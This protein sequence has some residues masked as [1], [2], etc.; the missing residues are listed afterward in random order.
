VEPE[1]EGLA[2]R[3][4]DPRPRS[5]RRAPPALTFAGAGL[6]ACAAAASCSHHKGAAGAA[7]A[8]D[9]IVAPA[10]MQRLT[11]AQYDNTV[12]DLLGAGGDP[13]AA[14]AEDEEQAGYAAN[15]QLPVQ[16]LQL[17][18]YQQAAE[19]LAAQ[20]VKSSY[21]SIVP[22]TPAKDEGPCVDQFVRTFGKRAFRRPLADGEAA[23]YTALFGVGRA[24]GDFSAGVS[25]VVAAMLQS[26]NFLYRIEWGA[27]G[28]PPEADGAVPLSSYEVASRLSYFLWNTMPDDVLLGAADANQLDT[29]DRVAAMAQR[30]LQDPRARD[31]FASF[32][33]QW[34]QL[35]GLATLQKT[36]P[37][38]TPDLRAAMNDEVVALVDAVVRQG[39]GRLE[40]L[41]T[42]DFSLV[43]GPLFSVYGLPPP[44]PPS[45]P[46]LM[47]VSLPAE[48][49]G[50]LTLPA[51]LAVHAHADQTSIVH[52][53]LLVREQFLCTP[54]PPPPANVDTTV[55]PT[56]ANLTQRQFID[57]HAQNGAC[58][59]C[60]DLMDPLGDAFEEFDWIGRF[61]Q[62]DG[63]Q[64]VDSTGQLAGTSGQDGAV[65][66]AADLAHRLASA[67]E[68]R[69]CVLRQWFRYLFGRV[70]T[71]GDA[72]T[73]AL[74]MSSFESGGFRIPDLVVALTRTR[75]FRYRTK[76]AP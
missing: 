73:L 2:A 36:D 49:A 29:A 40:T 76:V 74:A 58:S 1:S 37:A 31:G 30:M 34:L 21:A 5:S 32:H 14:F 12:R 70:E 28:A 61:R 35:Q 41:L 20:A 63:N 75:S 26:P 33:E 4:R 68:V 3:R 9:E 15:T 54:I 10:P 19:T 17:T 60:H 67:P 42:A 18:Q 44:S 71:D 55:P 13:A 66:N 48:R 46:V 69:D 62:T 39:D 24:G 59:G 11:H 51:V 43:R 65:A 47:R 53:G 6:V 22:C 64:P 7:P 38:F 57:A 8:S 52:R 27:P 45:S 16:E 50:V 56:A 23:A 25:I 72:A